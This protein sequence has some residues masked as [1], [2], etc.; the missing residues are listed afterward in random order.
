MGIELGNEFT[1]RDNGRQDFIGL[2]LI[3]G[4]ANWIEIDINFALLYL[5]PDSGEDETGFA[6]ILILSKIKILGEDGILGQRDHFPDL[7]LE[8]S[9]LIPTGNE[10]E[11]LGSGELELGLLLAVEKNLWRFIGRANIGYFATNIPVVDEN[12]EDRFFYGFEVDLPLSER[13]LLGQELTG[14]FGSGDK[15]TLFTLTGFVFTVTEAVAFN[16]GLE[17]G[18]RGV[19][20]AVT[21]IA[22][23]TFSY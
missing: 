9:V 4:I 22:G 8:P 19:Q 5:R 13:L 3:Y 21:G 11:G 20:S 16:L 23:V 1:H 12:F 14:A 6:D 7:V 15:N 2:N 10:D 17:F 18:L